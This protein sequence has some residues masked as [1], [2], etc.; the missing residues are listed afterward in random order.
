MCI[1]TKRS[2]KRSATAKKTAAAITFSKPC[3]LATHHMN[4]TPRSNDL[5]ILVNRVLR[6]YQQQS[7]Q[8]EPAVASKSTK[9]PKKCVRFDASVKMPETSSP[10]VASTQNGATL[11]TSQLLLQV[12]IVLKILET[13]GASPPTSSRPVHRQ[14]SQ[15][16]TQGEDLQPFRRYP[17]ERHG[18]ARD[19]SDGHRGSDETGFCCLINERKDILYRTIAKKC[20]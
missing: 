20:N 16:S 5:S 12:R 17:D 13:E 8:P 2:L 7:S 3:I 14:T 9:S 10:Q 4:C 11:K 15:D 1:S 19:V 6:Q 18:Q